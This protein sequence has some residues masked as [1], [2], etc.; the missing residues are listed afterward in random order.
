MSIP[1]Q[2]S[3]HEVLQVEEPP[4]TAIP[5]IVAAVDVPV[6]VQRLPMKTMTTR[7]F[8]V[9]TTNVAHVL[10]ADH[11]R[12][13]TTIMAATQK[14]RVA[15]TYDN[16]LSTVYSALWPTGVP[17]ILES[18]TDLWIRASTDTSTVSVIVESWATSE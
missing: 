11:Y 18:C 14:I 15:T 13:R 16:A 2:P 4:L 8:T 3:E 9:G 10:R 7:T 5:V 12:N 17:L 1:L 6:R